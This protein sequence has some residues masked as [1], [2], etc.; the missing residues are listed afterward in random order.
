[1]E[2]SRTR[3]SIINL[4]F[5]AA[6]QLLSALISFVTRTVFIQVF[7]TKYL[8]MNA[9]FADV[10]S[11]LSLADLGIGTAMSY[12]FYRPLAEG[13]TR[14]VTALA[15]FYQRLYRRVAAAVTA[16]GLLLI[17]ILPRIITTEVGRDQLT[18]Y[19]LI[20]LAGTAL[21]YLCC[22]RAAVLAADQRS[23]VSAGLGMAMGLLRMAA[24]LA[25]MLWLKSYT[26]Y[27]AAAA[28]GVLLH[29]VLTSRAAVRRYS[30]LRDRAE[31]GRE[32][33]RDIYQSIGAVF[34]YKLSSL[35][36]NAT[37]HILISVMAGTALAGLYSNYQLVQNQLTRCI[38]LVFTSLT[39]SVGNL[40]VREGADRRHEVFQC[41]QAVSFVV[42]AV[43]VPCYTALINDFIS[44]W[45]GREFLLS[46]GVVCAAGL[47]LYLSCVLQPLW[48][49]R[50]ATGLY[51]RTKWV[52]T[53]CAGLNILL[54][55]LLGRWMGTAGILLASAAARLATYVW[56]EPKLLFQEYFGRSPAPY[57]RRICQN[58]AL[59]A[60]LTAALAG[61][62][63]ALPA[64]SWLG[65]TARAALSAVL[66]LAAAA[67]LYGPSKELAPLWKKLGDHRKG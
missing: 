46:P 13:D 67:A 4:S 55:V 64:V 51:A 21:S 56:Y 28:A 32:D 63:R 24:Q 6:S 26:A 9:V 66:C 1:M 54:S 38:S 34:L 50:E 8:G 65:W 20:S 59:T 5:N 62:A 12:S 10:L 15:R 37:D 60:L 19:Y 44:I 14:R 45:L 39:A 18:L 17:P 31:L 40:V 53:V 47:N 30:F 23:Y 57:F 52:M 22:S 49:Y 48:S 29:N 16:A 61:L 3:K 58:A 43:A 7:S 27:L 25:A 41:E 11:L 2:G 42:C 33:A 36:L 35:L